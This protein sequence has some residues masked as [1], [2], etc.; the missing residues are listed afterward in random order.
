MP[1]CHGMTTTR[2]FGAAATRAGD[3]VEVRHADADRLAPPRRSAAQRAR[4]WR[5]RQV[6]TRAALRRARCRRRRRARSGPSATGST[7]T[8]WGG[9]R[10]PRGRR[11]SRRAR[12]QRWSPRGRTLGRPLVGVRDPTAHPRRQAGATAQSAASAFT[13]PW[14]LVE[15]SQQLPKDGSSCSRGRAR[16][17]SRSTGCSAERR[18]ARAEARDGCAQPPASRRTQTAAPPR[19]SPP[20]RTPFA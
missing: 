18:A 3:D 9:W 20:G 1:K 17:E 12:S 4:P 19:R 13:P 8:A 16:N 14:R 2:S 11:S 15:N 6:P 10:R 7:R 5:P